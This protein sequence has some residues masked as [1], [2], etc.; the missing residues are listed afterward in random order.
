MLELIRYYLTK[1]LDQAGIKS[2][3]TQTQVQVII[4]CWSFAVAILG[5]FM[6]DVLG[7]RLQTFIGVG[8]MVVTLFLI[9]AFIKSMSSCPL[10]A[11]W[12][13]LLTCNPNFSV[14]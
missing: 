3:V 14:W 4:N 5:S 11:R 1:I 13:S 8:G 6:L 12:T 10:R 7:R 2:T 9:G